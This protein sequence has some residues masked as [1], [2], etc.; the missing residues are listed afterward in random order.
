MKIGV[1][2]DNTIVN[3]DKSFSKIYEN[4]F[5]IKKNI[6]IHEK[7]NILK[8]NLS[9]KKW[10]HAQEI[11]Y[12]EYLNKFGRV[13][14]GFKKFA[15]RCHTLGHT[16]EIVS[17]KSNYSI[18][19]NIDLISPA[20]YFINR[21]IKVDKVFFFENLKKKILHINQSN[22]DYFIDD[23]SSVIELI[24]LPFKKKIL[25]NRSNIVFKEK[26]NEMSHWNIIEKYILNDPS[27]LEL[28]S[29]IK[30]K[31]KNKELKII[32]NNSSYNSQVLNISDKKSINYKVK[33]SNRFKKR[34]KSEFKNVQLLNNVQ[35]NFH[36]IPLNY[37]PNY[38]FATYLW[39]DG[40]SIDKVSK[41]FIDDVIGYI[42]KINNIKIRKFPLKRFRA[43]AS[44]L[45]YNDILRQINTR[46]NSFYL[47]KNKDIEIH[48][49]ELK[50]YFDKIK[51]NFNFKNPKKIQKKEI[52]ISPSDLSIKNFIYQKNNK[53]FFIDYEYIGYD[54]SIKLICDTIIHPA[55][56]FNYNLSKYFLYN[57]NSNVTK[58]NT[59]RF[60]QIFHFYGLIWCLIILNPIKN[61]TLDKKN[62]KLIINKSKKLFY[63]IKNEYTKKYLNEITKF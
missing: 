1:D 53:I 43:S 11:V 22:Y 23:L 38:E 4:Y 7:K 31:F 20:N 58:I 24:N 26:F 25:F 29:Y 14:N 51:K 60:K 39:I 57:F 5:K 8:K 44:C 32:K 42:I 30:K 15:L 37:D 17:H 49:I 28:L 63:K 10:T 13:F 21:K 6:K 61:N 47:V 40:N 36:P 34:I 52:I 18:N 50:K 16:L 33:I 2:F 19:R 46:F 59:D 35:P 62:T 9:N 12:G 27:N 55:N 45:T 48:L 41:S 56:N 3:H 54:D